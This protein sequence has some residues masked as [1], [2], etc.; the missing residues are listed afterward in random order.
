MPS[1][2]LESRERSAIDSGI[3]NSSGSLEAQ[4]GSSRFDPRVKGD[5]KRAGIDPIQL[6]DVKEA[7]VCRGSQTDDKIHLLFGQR[8]GG[9]SCRW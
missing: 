8:I 9:S 6:H 1:S 7:A 5:L 4:Q 3:S 2:L